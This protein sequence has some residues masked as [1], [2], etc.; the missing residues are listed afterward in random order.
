LFSIVPFPL[1]LSDL[2][3]IPSQPTSCG[4][5]ILVTC[6][7]AIAGVVVRCGIDKLE[8]DVAA[9]PGAGSF[10]PAD[11]GN[12]ADRD[13]GDSSS[14]VIRDYFPSLDWSATA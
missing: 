11:V 3:G 4:A 9:T 13:T 5:I 7:Q 2:A 12:L 8:F 14:R 1:R 10:Q 6:I